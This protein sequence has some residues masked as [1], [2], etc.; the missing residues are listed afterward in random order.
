LRAGLSLL[1]SHLYEGRGREAKR[2][3]TMRGGARFRR[4]SDQ[5]NSL[6]TGV[7]GMTSLSV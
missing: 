3:E 2:E 5:R 7:L 1:L 6:P 4:N